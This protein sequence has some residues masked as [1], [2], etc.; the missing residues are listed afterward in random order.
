MNIKM[1]N[2]EYRLGIKAY[3][4]MIKRGYICEYNISK[5]ESK[6]SKTFIHE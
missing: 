4:K 1:I 2:H 3:I 5:I 6:I